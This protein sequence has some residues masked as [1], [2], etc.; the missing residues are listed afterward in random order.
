MIEAAQKKKPCAKKKIIVIALA[1]VM[2]AAVMGGAIFGFY[3]SDAGHL[4]VAN[5]KL[6]HYEKIGY[7][8]GQVLLIGSSSMEYWRTSAEDLSPLTSYNV[9]VAGTVVSEWIDWVDKMIVPF[10]P[11]AVVVYAGTN[12]ITG[13]KGGNTGAETAELLKTLFEKIQ[14]RLPDAKIYFIA[15][16]QAPSKD[17]VMSDINA[18]NALIKELCQNDETLGYIDCNAE[19]LNADGSYKNELYRMDKLHFNEKGYAV[20]QKVVVPILISE[21]A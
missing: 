17:K 14:N 4:Y 1:A 12:N 21:L 11:R 2:V 6:G 15:I 7:E 9:G 16:T 8:K 13:K 3:S 20:W 5:Q 18:C 19:V 10:S